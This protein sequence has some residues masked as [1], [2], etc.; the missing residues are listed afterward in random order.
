[1]PEPERWT[2]ELLIDTLAAWP[3]DAIVELRIDGLRGELT[4][5]RAG[6]SSVGGLVVVLE[7]N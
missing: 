2:V 1:M 4:H 5:L 3:R 7:S 6:I